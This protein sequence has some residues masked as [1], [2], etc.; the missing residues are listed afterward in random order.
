MP[1]SL[2]GENCGV[3]FQEPNVQRSDHAPIYSSRLI[4]FNSCHLGDCRESSHH[5]ICIDTCMFTAK[6]MTSSI[7][8]LVHFF[9]PQKQ[10]G[11]W[12]GWKF[13]LI[14]N[15]PLYD[16][17]STISDREPYCSVL[18]LCLHIT[19]ILEHIA[20]IRT[21]QSNS[22]SILSTICTVQKQYITLQN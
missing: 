4:L 7:S 17:E 22:C 15:F 14:N 19:C 11:P 16:I 8:T 20:N 5:T 1:P 6:I 13:A 10:V 21:H 9:F 18:V 2:S 3:L 12:K